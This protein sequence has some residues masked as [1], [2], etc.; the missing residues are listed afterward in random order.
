MWCVGCC[1]PDKLIF[2]WDNTPINIVPGS[3]RTITQKGSKIIELIG[4]GDKC[5]IAAVVCGTLSG[6]F[7][8]LQLIY[9]GKTKACLP[10]ANFPKD[11][12]LIYMPNHW[13][14]RRQDQ[15]IHTVSHLQR[16]RKSYT[17]PVLAIFNVFY[18][19]CWGR[20]IFLLSLFLLIARISCSLW[21]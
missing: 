12:L 6:D 3:Q 18:W 5:Q 8:P 21:I 15:R 1:I 7:L 16:K 14:K 4:L 2:N 10:N 9:A 19:W 20:I 11:W 13:S 17:F